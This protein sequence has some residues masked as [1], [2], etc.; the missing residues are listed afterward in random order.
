M[1]SGMLGISPGRADAMR[2][3]S[4]L[5]HLWDVGVGYN[6]G[7]ENSASISHSTTY[8]RF[9]TRENLSHLSIFLKKKY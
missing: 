6:G 8:T 7:D 5:R 9:Y 1:A 2:L 4:I 3:V